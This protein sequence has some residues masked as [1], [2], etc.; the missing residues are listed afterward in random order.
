MHPATPSALAIMVGHPP[1]AATLG[2][3]TLPAAT[4]TGRGAGVGTGGGDS[5]VAVGVGSGVLV[6]KGV[7]VSMASADGI[8]L[9]TIGLYGVAPIGADWTGSSSTRQALNRMTPIRMTMTVIE[10]VCLSIWA[11]LTPFRLPGNPSINKNF[12]SQ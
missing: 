2:A 6:G 5:R 12:A 3:G 4:A 1:V 11:T 7:A 8:D 10:V 9:T